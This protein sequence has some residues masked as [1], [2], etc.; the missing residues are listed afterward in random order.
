MQAH[1]ML[2]HLSDA[3]TVAPANRLGYDLIKKTDFICEDCVVAKTRQKN[4]QK[5]TDKVYKRS[6]DLMYMDISLVKKYSQGRKKV[7]DIMGRCVLA[8]EF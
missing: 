2:G 3:K 1:K 4:V 6:G 5:V 8:H 7:L